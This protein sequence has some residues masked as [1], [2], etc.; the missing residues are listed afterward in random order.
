[1][2]RAHRVHRISPAYRYDPVV[3]TVSTILAV[4]SPPGRALRG[5]I[6]VSGSDALT[7]F[8]PHLAMDQPLSML[9]GLHPSR[10]HLERVELP[11]FILIAPAPRSY[12][13]ENCLELQATGNPVLLERIIDGLLD[14]ARLRNLEAR[15]AEPGEFTARAY[16]NGKM[17]LVQAEGVEATIAAC[18]DAQLRA[19]GLLRDGSLGKFAR[20]LADN[21]A[22]ALALVEAGIDFTDQEDVVA[23]TPGDL[24]KRLSPL[25]DQIDAQLKRS[26]GMEHLE[27]IPWVVLQGRPNAGKSTLFNALL[28]HERAVVS[29]IAGTTRDVLAEPL[30]IDTAHGKA[31]VMLVDLAG[32]AEEESEINRKMQTAAGE[33]LRRAELILYCVPCGENIPNVQGK[34]IVVQ[35]KGDLQKRIKSYNLVVSA[36]SGAGLDELRTLITRRMADRAVSLEADLMALRPRHDAALRSARNNLGEALE[37]VSPEK[38]EY[39]LTSPELVASSMRGALDD[40]AAL[41]GDITPDEVLGR[42]FASFCVG[43]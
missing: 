33:A 27:E 5:V 37:L 13:G 36:K 2:L 9:R 15:R 34:E 19:A 40:L 4:A 12:T 17:D 31:E 6:R 29:Q 22:S 32:A 21:L 24:Q 39:R 20:Q 3:D 1:M 28:G 14:S 43:K 35:T 30:T 42:V 11:A 38:D 7:L 16:L 8:E 23:I 41:A 18:S 26:V 25:H 10:L